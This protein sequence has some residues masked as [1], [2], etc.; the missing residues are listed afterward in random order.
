MRRIE[1]EFE[2]ERCLFVVGLTEGEGGIALRGSFAVEHIVS[3]G[4][5]GADVEGVLLAEVSQTWEDGTCG[6]QA[7]QIMTAALKDKRPLTLKDKRLFLII[8]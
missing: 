2:V 6:V 5:V 8:L 4:I 1:E 7:A 3:K